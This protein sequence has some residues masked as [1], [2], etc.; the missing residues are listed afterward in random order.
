M[1]LTNTDLPIKLSD[2]MVFVSM[3]EKITTLDCAIF[4]SL[5]T[6]CNYLQDL[7]GIYNRYVPFSFWKWLM[8]DK[9]HWMFILWTAQGWTV[10]LPNIV[11]KTAPNILIAAEMQKTICHSGMVFQIKT[12]Y[13]GIC[14]S[15]VTNQSKS[16]L[17]RS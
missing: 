14:Y 16:L 7:Y 1:C 17:I 8:V 6:I 13:L 10:P 9:F 11:K 5:Q 2:V 3:F 15:I 4:I 12:Q